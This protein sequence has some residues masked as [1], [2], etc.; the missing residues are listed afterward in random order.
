MLYKTIILGLLESHPELHRQL[1][2]RRTLLQEIDRYSAELRREHLELY[3]LYP[4]DTAREMAVAS[5]EQRIAMEAARHTE[6]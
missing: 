4:Q 5:L 3:Q 6:T 2:L 1:R